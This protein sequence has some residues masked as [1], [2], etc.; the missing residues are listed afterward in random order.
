MGT[1]E[2]S[3]MFP[4]QL[5]EQ[6]FN[7][8]Y[9]ETFDALIE[10]RDL[11]WKLQDLLPRVLGAGASAGALTEEGAR[12]LDPEGNLEAGIPL[13]PPEGDAG[14]GMVATNSVRIGSD[15]ESVQ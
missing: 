4:I 2:A 8:A 15:I 1:G 3:G 6:D 10:G 14:T 9:L 12:L 7:S 11:G 5:D 13:C